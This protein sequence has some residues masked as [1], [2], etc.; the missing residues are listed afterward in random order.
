MAIVVGSAATPLSSFCIM[1]T[2]FGK[3][4]YTGLKIVKKYKNDPNIKGPLPKVVH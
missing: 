1:A 4:V 3:A 2:D